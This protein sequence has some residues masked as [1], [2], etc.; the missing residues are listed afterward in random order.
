M[1]KDNNTSAQ[2]LRIFFVKLTD[3]TGNS[4]FDLKT[5]SLPLNMLKHAIGVV[6]ATKLEIYH[7]K[8]NLM[9]LTESKPF[10]VSIAP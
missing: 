1:D 4:G 7:N 5:I 10:L 8:D 2:C 6:W 9:R 3:I